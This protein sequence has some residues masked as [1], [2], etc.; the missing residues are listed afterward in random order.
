MKILT[1]KIHMFIDNFASS[2]KFNTTFKVMDNDN[3]ILD[4]EE[5]LENAT[6]Y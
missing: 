5:E 4:Y 6:Y 3:D 2:I 1:G